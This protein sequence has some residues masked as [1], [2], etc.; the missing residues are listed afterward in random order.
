L[1]HDDAA[2]ILGF[3]SGE[4]LVQALMQAEP[5]EALIDRRT[6]ERMKAE[7][8]DM[9]TDG[10]ISV[11]AM[12]AIHNESRA[13]VLRMEMELLVSK[14]WP[15]A[16][17]LMKKLSRRLPS[18][19]AIRDQAISAIARKRVR[20]INPFLYQ[21]A[22]RKAAREAID[23]FAKG[24]IE[25]AFEAKQRELINHEY[26]RAAVAAREEV[27]SI[28]R[29]M[30]RFSK[31]SVRAR[32]GRA[33]ADYLEQV[34]A[35]LDHYD[36][37]RS[38]SNRQLDRRASLRK[39]VE[40]HQKLGLP[41]EMPEK[42]L[43]DA[44]RKHFKEATYAELT[45]IRDS[46]KQVE[47]TAKFKTELMDNK[48]H[49]D[50]QA[51]VE[52]FLASLAAHHD[53]T[54]K[55]WDLSPSWKSKVTDFAADWGASHVKIEFLC[56]FLDGHKN[57]GA[58]W[59]S[60]FKPFSDAANAKHVMMQG[61]ADN[62]KRIL[63][64]FTATELAVRNTKRL[65][66][67]GLKTG[68]MNGTVTKTQLFVMALNWGNAY[69]RQALMEGYGWTESQVMKAFDEHLDKRDWD[70]I[71]AIWDYIDT[72]WPQVAEH[73]RSIT[74][75]APQKVQANEVVTRHGTYRGG[76]YPLKYDGNLSER[77]AQL[78]AK[79]EAQ[80]MYGGHYARAM[81]QHGHTIERTNS[82]GKPVMLSLMVLQQ[83][84]FDVAHD[85]THR[86]AIIDVHYL[87]NHPEV[88][89]AIQN[90]AGKH[91]YKQLNIW[92]ARIAGEKPKPWPFLRGLE[93]LAS[94]ARRGATA[95]N[96]GIKLTTALVQPTGYSI[97]VKELGEA[98]AMQGLH[99]IYGNPAKFHEQMKLVF[100]KSIMMRNRS[101]NWERDIRD[102]IN[103]SGG[104]RKLLD[105][106][107]AKVGAHSPQVAELLAKLEHK[108]KVLFAF[109]GWA[110]LA[111]CLPTWMGA[112]HKAIDGA[113]EGVEANN[114]E[115]A[116]EYADKMVRFTQG[117]GEKKDLAT[118]QSGNEMQNLVSMFFSFFSLLGNQFY[119]SKGQYKQDRDNLQLMRAVFYVW[120]IPPVLEA[121][122]LDRGPDDDEDKLK[123]LGKTWLMYPMNTIIGLRDIT[124][125]LEARYGS[126]YKF[127]PV[128]DVI[129]KTLAAGSAV[130]ERTLGDKDEFTRKDYKDA[131]LALGYWMGLPS[132][133]LWLTSEYFYDWL[134]TGDVQPSNPLEVPYRGLVTGKPKE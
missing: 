81:T 123:W 45:Q 50:R 126:G 125:A 103:A 66:I 60:I 9:L 117:S 58:A 86:K 71:Q 74:G 1:H 133:Q 37:R 101:E 64:V 15:T 121:I 20:D 39:W 62:M 113:A 19:Q 17:G 33:G 129:D 114:E 118:V 73:E 22:E 32:L 92:L 35:I 84:L 23:A 122:V 44:N 36:F 111:V 119:R 87:V 52:E 98:Y 26:Y 24:D 109:V 96:M 105:E 93:K 69:N 79:T 130:T 63:G 53:I 110:D 11:E 108:D 91:V 41:V 99:E 100:S 56:D 112:Y 94:V 12:K 76:Y 10:T 38:I 90:A 57:R 89:E 7:H 51:Q 55:P 72:F 13:K 82:G 4:E 34:D 30:G 31:E 21:R 97:S 116:I 75:L 106:V 120:L 134:V 18:T 78:D 124:R 54:G 80:R 40:N 25:A 49:R 83:H 29:Y 88:R 8:G 16:K 68:K 95:V 65:H 42:L 43:D 61:I 131:S 6:D 102:Y 85:L 5:M 59:M 127:S 27:D 2:M 104:D 14:D 107:V 70:A 28:V 3:N 47:F 48:Q 128:G 46:V 77:Q 67:E 115:Q 132:R